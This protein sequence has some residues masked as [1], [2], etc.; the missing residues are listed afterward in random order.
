MFNATDFGQI[1]DITK[2]IEEL[3]GITYEANYFG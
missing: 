3:S 2:M 1:N